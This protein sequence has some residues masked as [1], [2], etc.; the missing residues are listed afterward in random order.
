MVFN[1]GNSI[2]A[3]EPEMKLFLVDAVVVNIDGDGA[4]AGY[5]IGRRWDGRT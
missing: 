2:N 3:A 1:L 4:I 5:R